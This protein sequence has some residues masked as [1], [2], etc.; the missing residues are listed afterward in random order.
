MQCV[1]VLVGEVV[2]LILPLRSHNSQLI[3]YSNKLTA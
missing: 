2:Y 1:M 3:Y